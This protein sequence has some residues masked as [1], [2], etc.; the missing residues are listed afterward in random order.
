M[1]SKYIDVPI[2]SDY[3]S[4]WNEIIVPLRNGKSVCCTRLITGNKGQS[5]WC[6]AYDPQLQYCCRFMNKFHEKY[7]EHPYINACIDDIDV[8]LVGDKVDSA[9]ISECSGLCRF[10]DVIS[11]TAERTDLMMCSCL[12]NSQKPWHLRFRSDDRRFF[13]LSLRTSCIARRG[14]LRPF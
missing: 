12:S 6:P 7:A 14:I 9:T 10:I 2:K 8:D 1:V 11:L 3:H 13:R 5:R 4:Y